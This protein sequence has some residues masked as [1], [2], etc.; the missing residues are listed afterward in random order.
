MSAHRDDID[1]A[2]LMD[3]GARPP[4]HINCACAHVVLLF[5]SP[6]RSSRSLPT[7]C[8]YMFNGATSFNS[9]V[10]FNTVNVVD[11]K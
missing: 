11:I 3:P 7:P 10:N 9:P 2:Q 5:S 4:T 8:S 1:A 6:S